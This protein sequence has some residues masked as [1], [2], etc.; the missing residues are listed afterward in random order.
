[1]RAQPDRI[2]VTSGFRQ[3]L[4]LLCSVAID[5]GGRAV[6]L[7]D[8]CIRHHVELVQRAGLA[9]RP[10]PVDDGGAQ[11]ELLGDEGLAL[12]TPAHQYPARRPARAGPA[13][14]LLAW[15][16]ERGAIVVEDDYD[17]EFRYD[18]QPVGALQGLDPD[19]VVYA[20]TVSKTLAPAIRLGWL[21]LPGRYW[22]PWWRPS[23]SW[24][25][26]RRFWSS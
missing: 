6:G 25:P 7:E 9:V 13:A 19:R 15:G 17:G 24:T 16:R 4:A 10:L 18:R 20:G 3:S 8:P 23:A 5:L 1:M 22:N 21:V 14:A 12:V 26:R 2:L 11:V